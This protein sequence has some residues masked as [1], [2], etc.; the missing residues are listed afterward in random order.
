[1]SLDVE[2]VEKVQIRSYARKFFAIDQYVT[3][4]KLRENGFF[5]RLVRPRQGADTPS[6]P[7]E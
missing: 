6:S 2:P 5:Y 7:K 3:N 1:V 4:L